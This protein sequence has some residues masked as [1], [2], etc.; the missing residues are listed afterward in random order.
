M[1]SLIEYAKQMV[2]IPYQW[3]GNNPM[4]GFD[5]SGLVQWVLAS[6]GQ[7]PAGRQNAEQLHDHFVKT[8]FTIPAPQPGALVFYGIPHINHVALAIDQLRVV[9]A[10]SGDETTINRD[11]A[12]KQGACVKIKP[13]NHRKDIV[14]ILMPAYQNLGSEE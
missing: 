10:A 12:R 3:G 9:E 11:I 7:D 8:G 2:N 13:F 14:A 6:V 5:C 1:K 4:Q